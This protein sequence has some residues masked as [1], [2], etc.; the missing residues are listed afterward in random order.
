MGG[1]LI[2]EQLHVAERRHPHVFEKLYTE[3]WGFER[4][5]ELPTCAWLERNQVVNPDGIDIRWVRPFRRGDETVYVHPR[6]IFADGDHEKQMPRDFRLI[7]IFLTKTKSGFALQ[8]DDAGVPKHASLGEIA[9]YRA[10]FP[11]LSN[12]YHP[13]EAL[14]SLFPRMVFADA[15]G[16]PNARDEALRTWCRAHFSKSE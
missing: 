4:V 2:H 12:I 11:G 10:L 13:T 3:E 15:S 8:L 16:A 7:G 5:P 9:E 6:V 14:A 1:L